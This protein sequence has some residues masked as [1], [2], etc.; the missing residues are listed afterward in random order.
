METQEE[1]RLGNY[2][3]YLK[4][5]DKYEQNMQNHFDK[6]ITE[7]YGSRARAQKMRKNKEL[8]VSP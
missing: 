6:K 7:K 5:W 4:E 8:L 3:K 2:Q 1:R